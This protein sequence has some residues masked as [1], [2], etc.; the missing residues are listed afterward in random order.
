LF[1]LIGV[2]D[3]KKNHALWADYLFKLFTI[4]LIPS[5]INAVEGNAGAFVALFWLLI[6]LIQLR[7]LS[8]MTSCYV[9]DCFYKKFKQKSNAYSP[10]I[11]IIW[12]CFRKVNI[13]GA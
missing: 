6:S 7:P 5:F 8:Y 10:E 9:I 13:H 4:R 12:H 3:Q 1:F 11:K 2:T